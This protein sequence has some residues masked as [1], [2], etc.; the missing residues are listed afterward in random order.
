VQQR[1]LE[2]ED[3]RRAVLE[4]VRPLGPQRVPLAEA[5]GRVLAEDVVA[6]EPVPAFD[7]SAMDGFAVR[8]ADTNGAQAVS[9]ATLRLVGESRA[10]HPAAAAVGP[11]E[12]IAIS[13]GAMVPAGADAVVRV[14]DTGR[15]DGEVDVLVEAGQ[16]ANI[17]RAGEDV[18][19]GD[20]VVEAGAAIGPA[21]LGVLASAAR[22]EVSCAARPRLRV[23]V[24]GD[25][26]IGAADPLRPGAV[27]D[28]NAH[29]VPALARLAGAV[30]EGVEHVGDD[31]AAT[32][33]AL[34]E[35]LSSDVAVVCGGVS[36]GEHDH[37]RPALAELGAEEVFWGVA[38]RPGKPTW[39]GT[40]PG[41]AG[42]TF[43][44]PGNPVSAMV[45]FILLARP[46][47]LA[48]QGRDPSA[49]RATA[50]L[51]EDYRKKPGRAHAVRCRLR[52]GP[53]GWLA[54]PTKEQG[55]H[56]LTSMLGADA[57]ALI[58][59]GSEGV[60]AGERVTIELLGGPTMAA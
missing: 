35:A 38:L 7:N 32:R 25:E 43:G 45:T 52:P 53:E 46:A 56:V 37:V 23:V 9:P 48:M 13:T 15:R 24:S 1:L 18:R 28:S 30:V 2:I 20:R 59:T 4:R 57:L 50:T 14:E 16:G 27:R 10:G 47:L 44:L 54:R 34:A 19:A 6:P 5:L 11:G 49:P 51:E 33:G 21:E 31:P 3:A 40:S 39:F 60:A 29:T 42:L 36:V 22:P 55:S 17:R 12:A 41:G 8:A 26:L 58:E